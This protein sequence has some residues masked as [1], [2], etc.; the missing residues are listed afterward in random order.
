V[1]V[2]GGVELTAHRLDMSQPTGQRKYVWFTA[3]DQSGAPVYRPDQ[4]GVRWAD[5][6]ES[7]RSSWTAL[8]TGGRPQPRYLLRVLQVQTTVEAFG[9]LG[10]REQEEAVVLL[11]RA[12]EL[13]RRKCVDAY[14]ES[15]GRS[16]GS[17]K[18][19]PE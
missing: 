3:F 1:A 2:E 12:T 16:Q 9:P 6:F 8:L 14:Q 13:L 17:A 11:T 18:A 19:G 7:L 4:T 5:R 10:E 15:G